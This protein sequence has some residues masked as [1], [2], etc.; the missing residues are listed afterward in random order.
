MAPKKNVDKAQK[1]EKTPVKASSR[2]VTKNEVIPIIKEA[3]LVIDE[4]KKE[5]KKSKSK[6]VLK[7]S[8]VPHTKKV[9][10]ILSQNLESI[11]PTS[12]PQGVSIDDIP[13]ESNFVEA[14]NGAEQQHNMQGRA[15][16][17]R[18]WK[19]TETTRH[20]SQ[21]RQGVVA[22]LGKSLSVHMKEREKKKQIKALEMEMK[23]A[24]LQKITEKKEKRAEQEKRRL[25]NQYK[26]AVVA[27]INPEKLKTM[28][29]KQLRA[30]KKTSMNKNGQIELV[31]AY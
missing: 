22:N 6:L 7:E 30:V 21:Q 15:K 25:A 20:S 5:T 26:S 28:S 17:G 29:K 23:N 9:V 27:N 13:D 19:K 3:N 11:Q 31:N 16:S 24:R 2:K 12:E 4:E 18:T 8:H 14:G 1:K 10:K